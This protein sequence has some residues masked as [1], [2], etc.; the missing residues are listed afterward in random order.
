M[1]LEVLDSEPLKAWK[2]SPKSMPESKSKPESLEA[3]EQWYKGPIVDGALK[4]ASKPPGR[5]GELTELPERGEEE[6]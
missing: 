2:S 3:C 4:K 5:Q 1:W 6:D